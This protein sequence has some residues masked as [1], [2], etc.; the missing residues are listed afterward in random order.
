MTAVTPAASTPAALVPAERPAAVA[1]GPRW[2]ARALFVALAALWAVGI[3]IP[4]DRVSVFFWLWLG[5]VMWRW[6]V[7]LR[8]H[9]DFAK[10]WWPAFAILVFWTYSRGL[11]DN[12]GAPIRITEPIRADRWLGLG[13]LPT[14][15]LQQALCA[16]TCGD[17]SVGS[18]YDTI[19]TATYLTHFVTGLTLALVLWMNSRPQWAAWLRRYLTLNLVGL[20]ICVAVPMQP[21]WMASM[22]GHVHPGVDRLT[23]R[24]GSVLGVHV[25]QM[26]MGPIG[27]QVAA[28]PSLHAGTAALVALFGVSRLRSRWRWLLLG[29]PLLMAFTLVYYGEHYVVDVLAGYLL[30]AL[31]HASFSWWERRSAHRPGQRRR[32]DHPRTG[33]AYVV[34]ERAVLG[35]HDDHPTGGLGRD[36]VA[37]HVVG[38]D[39]RRAEEHLDPTR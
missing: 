29:Y 25:S 36:Q 2:V 1:A 9:L 34:G 26:V 15:R 23:G 30:A 27:N 35:D 8:S 5:A 32:T 24:G 3:G 19:F 28:M 18:W 39:T 13:E 16:P 33:A 12:L 11:A 22:G 4:A 37:D 38:D 21:P 7:P 20:A 6:G 31:V 10:D 17:P 14:Q